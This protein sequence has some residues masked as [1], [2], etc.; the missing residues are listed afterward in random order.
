M[1]TLSTRSLLHLMDQVLTPSAS[2]FRKKSKL[3]VST[4]EDKPY[5]T[6]NTWP[7]T[8]SFL[9]F[10]IAQPHRSDEPNTSI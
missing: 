7:I 6:G 4:D 9:T 5:I 1:K 2:Y 8:K 10:S 3:I